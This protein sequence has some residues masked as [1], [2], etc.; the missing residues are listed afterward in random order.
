VSRWAVVG[1]F[2]TGD[3]NCYRTE[4]PI[5]FETKEQAEAIAAVTKRLTPPD[6]R[7]VIEE[8]E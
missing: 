2:D 5:R 4:L 6:M 3:G 8:V 7:T 1:Y